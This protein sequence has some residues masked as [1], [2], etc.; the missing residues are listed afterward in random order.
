MVLL[1][2]KKKLSKIVKV[3]FNLSLFVLVSVFFVF[4]TFWD[5]FLNLALSLRNLFNDELK[6]AV[7][8]LLLKSFD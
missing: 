3:F 8:S 7:I 4:F 5:H 2:F 6:Q 1:I